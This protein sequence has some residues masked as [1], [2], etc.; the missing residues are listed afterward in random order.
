MAYSLGNDLELSILFGKAEFPLENTNQLL[1]LHASENVKFYVPML[2]FALIDSQGMLER[3]GLQDGTLITVNII[4]KGTV[5]QAMPFRLYSYHTQQ[6]GESI[7]YTIEAYYDC[8]KYYLGRYKNTF[9]GSSSTLMQVL[10]ADAGLSYVGATTN[11]LQLWVPGR[12]KSC[13]FARYVA[14]HGYLSATSCMAL[15]VTLRGSLVYSDIMNTKSV[16]FRLTANQEKG[17][18]DSQAYTVIQSKVSGSPG[19]GMATGG[20]NTITVKQTLM[21]FFNPQSDIARMEVRQQVKS[22]SINTAV[23][24]LI[25]EQRVTYAP[26]DCGNVSEN[27]N[28]AYYQNVRLKKLFTINGE[29]VLN[30]PC[31]LMLFVPFEFEAMTQKGDA[32][33]VNSGTYIT[34]GRIIYIKNGVYY[35]KILA[36][37]IGTNASYYAN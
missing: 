19:L 11:D 1:F 7:C 12:R 28:E 35:E 3:M 36:S 2:V 22:P 18:E 34:T 33:P 24:S 8:P 20:Y 27:Y 15:G 32:D 10:A 9:Y 25:G 23:R 4:S 6:Q 21:D 30:K 16:G 37:R 31:P 13:E 14:S 17:D 26:I 29:F 5:L